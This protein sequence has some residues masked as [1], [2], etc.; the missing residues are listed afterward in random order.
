MIGYYHASKTYFTDEIFKPRLVLKARAPGTQKL[1]VAFWIIL[2]SLE[3][4][5][6]IRMKKENTIM[7][8]RSVVWLRIIKLRLHKFSLNEACYI[9]RFLHQLRNPH[10]S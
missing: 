1:A 4:I 8:K 5:Y 3:Q 2:Y 9:E 10:I 6:I 7:R